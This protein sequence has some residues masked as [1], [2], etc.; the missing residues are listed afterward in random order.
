[1]KELFSSNQTIFE[2]KSSNFSESKWN[3][4]KKICFDVFVFFSKNKKHQIL[5]IFEK[6]SQNQTFEK[7]KKEEKLLF[8]QKNLYFDKIVSHPLNQ[9]KITPNCPKWALKTFLEISSKSL[10]WLSKSCASAWRFQIQVV[11]F[12]PFERVLEKC[13]GFVGKKNRKNFLFK[14]GLL[15]H[16]KNIKIQV[17]KKIFT[18]FKILRTVY[19]PLKAYSS[20]TLWNKKVSFSKKKTLKNKKTSCIQKKEKK[21]W[22]FKKYFFQKE[23]FWISFKNSISCEKMFERNSKNLKKFF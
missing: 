7:L 9:I 5:W 16:W 23:I 8:F 4:W 19:A 12:G 22:K 13:P 1:M 15:V 11:V 21:F 18:F 14:T 6:L 2:Q 10:V 20:C 3:F 17:L